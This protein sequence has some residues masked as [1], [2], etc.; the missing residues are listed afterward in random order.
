MS[1][2]RK[3]SD[4][5][6]SFIAQTLPTKY[7][8]KAGLVASVAGVALSVVAIFATDHP[9]IAVALQALTAF[10]FVEQADSE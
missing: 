1:K 5:G 8:S 4:K 9:E 7:K 3:V 10:G 6:L 2:H